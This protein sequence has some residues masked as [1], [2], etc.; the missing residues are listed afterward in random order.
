LLETN[1]LCKGLFSAINADLAARGLMMREGT[2]VDATLLAAWIS[3][4]IIGQAANQ[5]ITHYPIA[6]L[7]SLACVLICISLARF[8]RPAPGEVTATPAFVETF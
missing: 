2:L 8:L 6:G 1:N 3:G 7:V 5:Q 4:A